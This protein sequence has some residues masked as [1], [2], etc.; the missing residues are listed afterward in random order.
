MAVDF[1]VA[2]MAEIAALDE[3]LQTDER[4]VK[5][6]ELRRIAAL[7]PAPTQSQQPDKLHDSAPPPA[8]AANPSGSARKTTAV[9]ERALR[10]AKT[11]VAAERRIVPTR[12]IHQH[13]LNNDINVGGE[14][15]QNNLSAL[16]SRSGIFESHGRLGWTVMGSKVSESALNDEAGTEGEIVNAD[17]AGAGSDVSAALDDLLS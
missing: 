8:N 10:E 6:C 7:Y 1:R 16:I 2:L 3:E 13:L 11:Y 5:L 17:A 15:P 12:D 4:Y 14:S 9:R